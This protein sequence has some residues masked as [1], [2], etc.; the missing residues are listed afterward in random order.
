MN[1]CLIITAYKDI[2]NL[3]RLIHYAPEEWG[4]YIHLDKKSSIR[5][6]EI[7]K[8]AHVYQKKRI[9]WGAWEH[10]WV[11]HFL[12]REALT[13]DIHYD[14][15]HLIT[16]QDFFACPTN[17]FDDIVG[18][19][20]FN[21]M[22]IFPIPNKHWGWEMGLAI[23]KYKTLASF[24]DIRKNPLRLLNSI[25][26]YVQKLTNTQKALPKYPLYGGP[27]YCSITDEFVRWMLKSEFAN[28]L[29]DRLKH[30]I[31]SEEVFL[32]TVIM[33]SPFKDTVKIDVT[34]RYVDWHSNPK[35][36]FLDYSDYDKIIN[37]KNLFC[38]KTDSKI[39]KDLIRALEQ[40]QP[41]K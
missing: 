13:S 8:R 22:G 35:P 39:S 7:D 29:L 38:R 3:N 18:K 6:E 4:I 14:Y 24:G 11:V 40:L 10:L 17:E 1:H 37:T 27:L 16:G 33:N 41:I 30:S 31:C 5:K 19:Q 25:W 12:L 15:Y 34:L 32:P 26:K 20:G 28:R 21:Y 23:F 9:Y 2:E 36:K